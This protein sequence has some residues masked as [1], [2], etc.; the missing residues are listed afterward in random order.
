MGLTCDELDAMLTEFL[1]GSLT[2]D[3]EALAAEH[4]ATCEECTA[5]LTELQ[6]VTK[7]YR[8]H[9]TMRLPDQARQRITGALGIGE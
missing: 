6:G 5:E 9:G 4:L 8:E 7:L 3:E 2:K 1:D